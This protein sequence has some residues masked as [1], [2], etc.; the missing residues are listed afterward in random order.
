MG[1]FKR[2]SLT[3][4][5]LNKR[6]KRNKWIVW[7]VVGAVLLYGGYET[8]QHV[9]F[10]NS[11]GLSYSHMFNSYEYTPITTGSKQNTPNKATDPILTESTDERP[12]IYI[13]YKVGCPTCQ[14]NFSAIKKAIK[15]YQGEASI[16]W[17]NVESDLGEKMVDAYE[18]TNVPSLVYVNSKNQYQTYSMTTKI[19]SDTILSAIEVLEEEQ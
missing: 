14:E 7:G 12:V 8:Y 3:V 10:A 1:I 11:V 17:V 19:D 2:K 4:E 15:N 16:Y 9:Q 6:S 13:F 5:K 18:L